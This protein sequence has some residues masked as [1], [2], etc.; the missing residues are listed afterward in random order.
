VHC[1]G[2]DVVALVER[3]KP[4]VLFLD[5][6]R[7]ICTTKKG[8]SPLVGRHSIDEG[9]LVCL[10]HHPNV[11]IVTRNQH[12]DAIRQFLTARGVP[13]CVCIHSV[14]PSNR[15]NNSK[16]K[17]KPAG[18]AAAAAGLVGKASVIGDPAIFPAGATGVFVD[19]DIAELTEEG[20]ASL[21]GLHRVLF[22]R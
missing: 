7:T 1:D 8:S 18:A 13:P 10:T 11:H 12:G 6:D 21:T 5:F 15:S 16:K 22:T 4:Q 17:K 19:D 14:G 9:L 2:E 3:L 20:V